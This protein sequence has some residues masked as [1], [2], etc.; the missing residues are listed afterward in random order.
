MGKKTNKQYDNERI[1]TFGIKWE[2]LRRNKAYIKDYEKYA[3]ENNYDKWFDFFQ[4]KYGIL[5]P[6]NPKVS[7]FESVK[8]SKKIRIKNKGKRSSFAKRFAKVKY[9]L[10]AEYLH[11]WAKGA[12]CLDNDNH[13]VSHDIDGNVDTEPLSDNEI[14]EKDAIKILIDLDAPLR[15]ILSE[16]QKIVKQWQERRSKVVK[17]SANRLRL[18]EYK[19]YIEVYDLKNQGWAWDELAEKFYEMDVERGDINYAKRK[20]KRDYGRCKKI[21]DG[22]YRQI[23]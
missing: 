4:K 20:V 23:R 12:F 14:K 6:L 19:R 5:S 10:I 3:G 18:S 16:T 9:A 1:E 13:Y 17:N 21:I 7:F 2:F 11:Y 15:R 22:D 8:E